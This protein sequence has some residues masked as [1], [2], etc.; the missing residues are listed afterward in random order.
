MPTRSRVPVRTRSVAVAAE[1]LPLVP[2]ALIPGSDGS[3]GFALVVPLALV[4]GLGWG[5]LGRWSTMIALWLARF[6]VFSVLLAFVFV[7]STSDAATPA[8]VVF[9]VSATVYVGWTLLSA[10]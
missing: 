7:A 3:D 6:F 2:L 4:S 5:A 1:L 10:Y 8:Y 9:A